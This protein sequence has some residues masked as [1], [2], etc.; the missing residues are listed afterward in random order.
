MITLISSLLVFL[1][2]V[3]LHEFG[4]FA[5]AKLSGIKVNEFSIGMGPKIYQKQK[6]ET[7]YS[8]RALPVGGYVAMEGEEDNSHDPRAF[9]NVSIVKRMAVVLAGAFMNFVLAFIAFTLIFSIVGYGSS[10]IEKVISN[11]PADKAGIQSG[12]LIIKIN[13]NK[14]KDIY[15]INSIISKNQKEEM[16]FQINRGGNI[17]NV[18]IKPEYSV[19]NQMYLIGI[20]SKLDHSILKSISLGANRTLEMSKLILKS[21]K[22]MFSGSFK[23]EYLSGPVGVVQLIGSESSKGFL[24]FL[25]ILGL[26]SVNLG[27]FNL[28]PIPA[29]DGGKFLFLLIEALR[30]KPIDEKIE[31][32]LSLIGI[33]LLFSLMIYVT[34]FNDIGRLFNK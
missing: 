32:G 3:M 28:L 13:E 22:M 27:V 1:L 14:V 33:S 8:L 2:V 16:D 21:I 9:N 11:S 25:Q 15:D 20:T 7:F 12:D 31:Q 24:N 17:L 18:K 4:H 5:V 29:L 10:E 30:G 23:M 26:I 34:I 19:E 6:G